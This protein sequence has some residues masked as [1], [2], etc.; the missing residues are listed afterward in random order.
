MIVAVCI[1]L[2]LALAAIG[3]QTVIEFMRGD[4]L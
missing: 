2:V 1:G 4:R 3:L